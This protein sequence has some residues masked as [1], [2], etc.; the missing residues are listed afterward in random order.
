MA[1]G[2]CSLIRRP[3]TSW[4][5]LS[6]LDADG[7][8]G[9]EGRLRRKGMLASETPAR[10]SIVSGDKQTGRSGIVLAHL[11]KVLRLIENIWRVGRGIL[12]STM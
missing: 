2:D 9:S 6:Q 5:S 4:F 1:K 3:S 10:A 8:D 12:A 11:S 7:H